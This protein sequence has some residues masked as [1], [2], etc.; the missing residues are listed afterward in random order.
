MELPKEFLKVI[1]IDEP[2]LSFG[3][4]QTCDHPKGTGYISTG[5]TVARRAPVKF[6]SE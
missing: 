4:G 1:H 2:E 6:P 3:H 5:H